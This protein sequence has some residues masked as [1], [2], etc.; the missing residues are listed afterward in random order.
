MSVSAAGGINRLK[1]AWT[2]PEEDNKRPTTLGTTIRTSARVR[3]TD[4]R[5]GRAA[6]AATIRTSYNTLQQEA[7]GTDPHE[8][9]DACRQ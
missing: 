3:M 1:W 9:P 2:T 8:G 4:L 6:L 7:G 5:G